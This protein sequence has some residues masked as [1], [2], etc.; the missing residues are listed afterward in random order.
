MMKIQDLAILESLTNSHLQT[1]RIQGGLSLGV[2]L[3]LEDPTAGGSSI[4]AEESLYRSLDNGFESTSVFTM[5]YGDA[6]QSI[7][8]SS[9]SSSISIG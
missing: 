9:S 6:N 7:S 2:S 8:F 4:V 3:L 5:V 1:D